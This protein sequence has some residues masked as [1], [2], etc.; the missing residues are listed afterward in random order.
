VP[1]NVWWWVLGAIVLFVAI[2][3]VAEITQRASGDYDALTDRMRGRRPH[4]DT[5]REG[6]ATPPAPLRRPAVIVNP[7]KFNDLSD[8]RARIAGVCA[9]HGWDTPMWFETTVADPGTGQARQAVADGAVLVCPLGGDGTVRSVAK[10][11]AGT[12]TPLGLLPGGTGNLLARNL[13][14]PIDSVEK[15]LV[16]ALTGQNKTIDVG[17]VLLDR[18][19]EDQTPE[20]D[21][22]LVMAGLGFDADVMADAPEQLK[23]QVGV[24][25][26]LVSGVRNMKGTQFKARVSVDGDME[27]TQ[28]TRTVLFGNCGKLFGGLVLMPEAKIDDGLIDV[29]MLSPKGVVGWTAVAARVLSRQRHGH[30]IVDH[31]TGTRIR[32]R[33][34]RPEEVQLDGD[35]VGQVRTLTAWV[36]P[37]A[38]VVRVAPTA[39]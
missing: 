32:V 11:L 25:A 24:A 27:V 28:R 34:D 20:Q 26:Y 17:Q 1:E 3:A 38:L 21:M 6:P 29:V 35:N 9:A 22:F 18:S 33:L 15:A 7:T 2:G 19:G 31:R 5:F 12:E 4:R 8:V 39:S 23:N 16:V 30:S 10:G 37:G 14:L 13:D 36:Q